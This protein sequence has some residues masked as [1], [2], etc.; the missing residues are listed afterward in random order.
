MKKR[1]LVLM[2][3]LTI[4]FSVMGCGG[5]EEKREEEV[6]IS[7]S[8]EAINRGSAEK[9]QTEE[10]DNSLESIETVSDENIEETPEAELENNMAGFSI[11]GY[12][13]ESGGAAANGYYIVESSK[14]SLYGLVDAEGNFV[15]PAEYDEMEFAGSTE[16]RIEV[17]VKMEGKYGVYDNKNQ[18][19]IP[20]EYDL[21]KNGGINYLV[22]KDK[23]QS[24]WDFNGNCTKELND[25]GYDSVIGDLYLKKVSLSEG[26]HYFDMNENVV[27]VSEI[28]YYSATEV[29]RMIKFSENPEKE[30]AYQLINENG[31]VLYQVTNHEG[32]EKTYSILPLNKNMIKIFEKTFFL[33]TS[34]SNGFSYFYDLK[35]QKQID[36]PYL[37]IS[38]I[39]NDEFLAKREDGIDIYDE[40]GNKIHSFELSAYESIQ[41]EY[42]SSLIVVQYGETWRVYDEDGNDL[43]GER[44]QDVRFIGEFLELK[45]MDGECGVIDEK[46]NVVIPFGDLYE[47]DYDETYQGEEIKAMS[48]VA[49]K[50]Y[51]VTEKTR[52]DLL[53]LH[54]F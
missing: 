17:I 22:T 45:N 15:I 31:K 34:V 6:S 50:L 29:Y 54:I 14:S 7:D 38:E 16:D 43:M 23:T 5:K 1:I 49:G 35:E 42:D 24:V 51:I 41:Y 28:D 12:T 40:D 8:V 18:E 37:A 32:D 47:V 46:G 4:P 48:A 25:Y 3:V 27:D 52:D 9:E 10:V 33:N 39:A 44:F 26:I 11:G 13:Y 36:T 53:N 20:M 21:I 19:V 30:E 2:F